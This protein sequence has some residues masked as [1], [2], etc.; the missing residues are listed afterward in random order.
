MTEDKHQFTPLERLLR[1]LR[2]NKLKRAR[3]MLGK[4]H[5]AEISTLLEALPPVERLQAWELVE[6]EKDAEVLLHVN[7]E[8]RAQLIEEMDRDEL[9][10]ATEGI[11]IGDL[12]DL[13]QDMP[14]AVSDDFQF[15]AV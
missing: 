11:D 14:E 4:M 15:R 6:A 12:A 9:V 13:V 8:V 2:K 10:A 7:D 5:P 3:R 1:A